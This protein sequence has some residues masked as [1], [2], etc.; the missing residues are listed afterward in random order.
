MK[1]HEAR[2]PSL[3]AERE[4]KREEN[5]HHLRIYGAENASA[6]NRAWAIQHHA[7][8]NDSRPDE[9]HADDRVAALEHIGRHGAMLDDDEEIRIV[10][11]GYDEGAEENS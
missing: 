5:L 4:R 6:E 11:K 1:H 3:A 9:Y 8:K 10:P 2:G 7:A